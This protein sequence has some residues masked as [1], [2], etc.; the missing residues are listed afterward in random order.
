MSVTAPVRPIKEITA[1]GDPPAGPALRFYDRMAGPAPA[2]IFHGRQVL[3]LCGANSPLLHASINPFAAS[4]RFGNA[5][6][7]EI[8]TVS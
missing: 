3:G 6:C 7:T 4:K 5:V 8:F 1:Q 2:S